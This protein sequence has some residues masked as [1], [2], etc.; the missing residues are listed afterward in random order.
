MENPNRY[1]FED[2]TTHARDHLARLKTTGEAEILTLDGDNEVVVQDA[3]AY[4]SLLD[5]LDALEAVAAVRES[6]AEYGRGEEH[7]LS[8]GMNALRG[9]HGIPYSD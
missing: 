3:A 1:A 6:V 4:R 5:R 9:K 2:F 8:E 7:L